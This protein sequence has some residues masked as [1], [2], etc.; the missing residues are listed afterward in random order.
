VTAP[1]LGIAFQTDK[2]PEEYVRLAQLAESGGIDVV[3]AYHDLFFGPALGALTLIARATER[4][5]V[6]PAALNP[7]T[8]H[9]A[10]IAAQTAFL[11]LVSNG[12]AY[13]GLARGAWLD[14]LGLDTARPLTALREAVEVV[15]RLLRGDRSGFAGE[16]YTLAPGAGL[17]HEPLRA[18]VP[19]LIGGWG[20][21]T[22]AY[23]GAVADELK[24]GGTASPELVPVVRG[25]LGEGSATRIVVGCVTVVDE[26]GDAARARA[27]REAARYF[28][29]VARLDPTVEVPDGLPERVGALVSAGDADGAGALLP[30]GLLR[31]FTLAGTPEEVAAQAQALLEAGADRVDFGTPHGLTAE[32]GVELL[33]RRVMPLLR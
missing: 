27:R 13:V 21:R 15:R 16:R 8:L 31:R 4:V 1:E 18:D 24:V 33:V 2:A 23:A 7:F 28:P 3:S 22:V 17:Q 19:L 11:D 5:R 26:D 6:G 10:E 29:V 20:P 32:R 14:E 25:R 9:P 30:D 12:R